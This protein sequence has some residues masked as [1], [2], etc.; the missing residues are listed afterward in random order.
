MRDEGFEVLPV[1]VVI[2]T[3]GGPTLMRT[4]E[5][6]NAAEIRP[7]EIIVCVPD[8][9]WGGRPDRMGPNV[10]ILRLPYR[11]QVRQRAAGFKKA[12]GPYVLQLDD[13]LLLSG[14]DLKCLLSELIALGPKNAVAP[15]L[16]RADTR[17]PYTRIHDGWRGFMSSLIAIGLRG[18]RWGVRRM[19]TVSRLGHNYGVDRN[20]ITGR[21]LRVDWLPGGC[22]LHHKAELVTEDFYPF[23]GKAYAEDLLHSIHLTR[24][25]IDL[26][27]VRNAACIIEV[28]NG[29]RTFVEFWREARARRFVALVRGLGPATRALL[30]GGDV[31]AFVASRLW[32][33]MQRPR[34][35]G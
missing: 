18:A 15:V 4:I 32:G 19:G 27:A 34:V 5:S 30:T 23:P 33:A 20:R 11:G 3:L 21:R 8:E 12:S 26:W 16:V 1:S 14:R 24:R 29:P 9:Q 31:A 17:G 22:V 25:G 2:A 35:R 10:T 6:L 7:L 13:D 28:E